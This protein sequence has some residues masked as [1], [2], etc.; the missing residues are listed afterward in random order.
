[1]LRL[2]LGDP[3][4]PVE[5]VLAIGCHA[6]DIEIGCGGTLL[7]LTRASAGVE[8]TWLVLAASGVREDEARASASA[9]L[10]DAGQADVRVH[11]FRES[12]LPSQL[13]DVKEVFETLKDVAPDVVFTHSRHDLHQDHRVA[14]ELTWNTFRD[15]V[16]LEYEIPKYDGDFGTPNLYVPLTDVV[17]DTKVGWLIEFFESQAGKHWF[18]AEL[19]RS[20]M[21]LRGAECGTRHAEGF[22]ARKLTLRT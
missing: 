13:A 20:V 19:F 1:M 7:T 5:R 14:C 10:R 8:V 6:D 11:G 9:F 3:G 4:R 16:I 22:T 17:V 12:F 2:T 18:D 21:R 15:H